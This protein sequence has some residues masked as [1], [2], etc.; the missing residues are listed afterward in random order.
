MAAQGT[1]PIIIHLHRTVVSISS[2]SIF[3]L[4]LSVCLDHLEIDSIPEAKLFG[5]KASGDFEEFNVSNVDLGYLTEIMEDALFDIK[6]VVLKLEDGVILDGNG[7]DEIILTLPNEIDV[8][9][10]IKEM[11]HSEAWAQYLSFPNT[12][13]QCYVINDNCLTQFE[14]LADYLKGNSYHIVNV[15]KESTDINCIKR[16]IVVI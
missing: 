11:F 6:S 8:E 9:E 1:P 5:Q 15:Y 3:N 7:S 12:N 13:S 2:I 10:Y 16:S 4:P 14:S